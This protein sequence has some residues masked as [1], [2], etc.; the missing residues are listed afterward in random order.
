MKY[1]G[2]LNPL[3][4]EKLCEQLLLNK[5]TSPATTSNKK[6]FLHDY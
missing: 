4:M 3:P 1:A 6:M 2:T 5:P